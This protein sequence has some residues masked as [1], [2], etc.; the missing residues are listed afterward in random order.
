MITYEIYGMNGRRIVPLMSQD[1]PGRG[2]FQLNIPKAVR[3]MITDDAN[4]GFGYAGNPG[5]WKEFYTAPSGEVISPAIFGLDPDK[6]ILGFN[7]RDRPYAVVP[8]ALEKY[9]GPD[10]RSV[11][12]GQAK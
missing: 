12:F 4:E 11:I 7:G 10:W 9:F 5:K 8:L 1:P 6:G 2:P 3:V